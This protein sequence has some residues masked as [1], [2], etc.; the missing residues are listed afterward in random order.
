MMAEQRDKCPKCGAERTRDPEFATIY[1]C[2]SRYY[3]RHGAIFDSDDF[4]EAPQCLRN[5]LAQTKAKLEAQ[6]IDIANIGEELACDEPWK[7]F[8]KAIGELNLTPKQ[9]AAK[10]RA[11]RAD[12]LEEA[13][14]TYWR[15]RHNKNK[16]FIQRQI[17]ALTA[18]DER[19]TRGVT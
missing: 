10:Y 8:N 7:S 2:G 3:T 12:A 13:A 16:Q 6:D 4:G 14:N 17:R 1:K 5:Q 11:A 15:H 18:A 9:A 19:K